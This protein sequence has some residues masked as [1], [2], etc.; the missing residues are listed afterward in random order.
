M[1]ALAGYALLEEKIQYCF[2]EKKLLEEAIRH[3]SY[4]NEG[5]A[6]GLKSNERL[7]FLGDSV[8][9]LTAADFLFR[10]YPGLPEGRLTRM[11][12]ALVCEGSLALAAREL[13]LGSFLQFGRGEEKIGGR[14]RDSILAD[15]MEALFAAVYLDGGF[16]QAEVL[17]RRM[18][19]DHERERLQKF[20]DYK[21]ALQEYVQQDRK[22]RLEYELLGEQGPEHEKVFLSAVRLNGREIGR[23]E[24][25]SKKESQQFAAQD[26]WKNLG[27]EEE[28]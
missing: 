19:L 10:R 5:G 16:S 25:R 14:E 26:A 20:Y 6:P 12:A 22:N 13:H 4:L 3:S 23:G 28:F 7:E 17:V 18:I 24:G 9:G 27:V 1:I 15:A 21:T 11:R 8:L 2:Q